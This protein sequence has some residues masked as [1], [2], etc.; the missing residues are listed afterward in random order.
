MR[1]ILI[2]SILILAACTSAPS[3]TRAAPPT[4]DAPQS[5]VM[6][7]SLRQD[8]TMPVGCGG[9]AILP[10][11]HVTGRALPGT[12]CTISATG[13]AGQ[14]YTFA[15]HARLGGEDNRVFVRIESVDVCYRGQNRTI[16]V[17]GYVVTVAD[18]LAGVPAVTANGMTRTEATDVFAI[19]TESVRVKPD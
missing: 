3:P 17:A 2:A 19:T 15:G 11:L 9:R 6:P 13:P 10:S 18:G 4:P 5:L 16:P 7:A 8:E 12:A 1:P 14:I